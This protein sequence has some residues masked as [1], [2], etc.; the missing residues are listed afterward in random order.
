MAKV[1]EGV[2]RYVAHLAGDKERSSQL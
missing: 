1:V 2:Y